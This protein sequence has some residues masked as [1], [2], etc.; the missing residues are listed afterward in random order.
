MDSVKQTSIA[1]CRAEGLTQAQLDCI[2]AATEWSK[3]AAVGNCPAI[4]DHRP[5]WLRTP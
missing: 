3:L 4:K 5:S 2:L 1:Q